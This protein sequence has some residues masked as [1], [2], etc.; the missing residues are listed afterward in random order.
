[1]AFRR[2]INR[3]TKGS[4]KSEYRKQYLIAKSAAKA[5]IYW[6]SK[7]FCDIMEAAKNQ[8]GR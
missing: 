5:H 7:G 8:E 1:M 2:P 4:K 3:P 6:I